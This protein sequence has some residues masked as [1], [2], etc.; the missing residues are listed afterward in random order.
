MNK[1]IFGVVLCLA[2]SI[3]IA[4]IDKRKEYIKNLENNVSVSSENRKTRS[5]SILNKH[6]IPINQHLPYIEDEKRALVRNKEEIA[7]RA[8]ALLIVAVKAEGLEQEII[9]DLIQAYD[10]KKVLSP[11]EVKFINDKSPSEHDKTQFIWRYEA[12]WVLLWALGY[13][14][15]LSYPNDICDVPLAVSFL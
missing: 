10:L 1:L 12:A 13:I 9:E 15:E 8:M 7:K 11:N 2:S 6:K 14:D 4:D 3:S 5:E